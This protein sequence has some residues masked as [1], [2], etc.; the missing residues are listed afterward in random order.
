MGQHLF[1]VYASVV[2]YHASTTVATSAEALANTMYLE[3][4]LNPAL[5][6]GRHTLFPAGTYRFQGVLHFAHADQRS[7]FL[8]GA[9]LE[10]WDSDSY[11]LITGERQEIIGL[12][13]EA[14]KNL[15][16]R[17]PL[18]D[19]YGASDLLMQELRVSVTLMYH[20]VCGPRAAV[21]VMCLE[22]CR[23]VGGS[24]FGNLEPTTIGLWLASSYDY[25]L[26]N[27][28][29]PSPGKW[30]SY[31]L[32]EAQSTRSERQ[33]IG[34]QTSGAYEVEVF[35][36]RIQAFG[37][38]VR[39]GCTTDSADFI[40][41]IFADNVDGSIVVRDDG[42]VLA[43]NHLTIFEQA[44]LLTAPAPTAGISVVSGLTL[45][46]C[47]FSGAEPAQYVHVQAPGTE[48][49]G[50]SIQGGGV[51]GCTFGPLPAA[52]ASGSGEVPVGK[53]SPAPSAKD[54]GAQVAVAGIPPSGTA[55]VQSPRTASNSKLVPPPASGKGVEPPSNKVVP[56]PSSG[57]GVAQ[58]SSRKV[59]PPPS[60]GKGVAQPSS[61]KAVPPPSMGQNAAGL[62]V[63]PAVALS[64][65][66]D[67]CIFRIDGSISGVSVTGCRSVFSGGRGSVWIVSGSAAM[68]ETCDLFN[69]WAE[70]VATGDQ[71]GLLTRI[72]ADTSGV[73]TLTAEELCLQ[74][75]GLG[76]LDAEPALQGGAYVLGSLRAGNRGLRRGN[77]HLVLAQ[78]LID[79]SEL[80][81]VLRS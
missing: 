43:D 3:Q 58:P 37:W 4:A 36:T 49:G 54:V 77:E 72:T 64:G 59:V 38:A 23:F 40:A 20:S 52:P 14:P 28:P 45:V 1:D 67:G 42:D 51:F 73:L 15:Y 44:L 24:I 18:V 79:L 71:A 57:K 30:N 11:L 31:A 13:V 74:T 75:E 34:Q 65:P 81:L 56:P 33:R 16:A 63:V 17:S 60:S 35:G 62:V 9:V 68:K 10:P 2:D 76:V 21:R 61:S 70:E 5:N 32:L 48:S 6:G 80:G 53:A 46:G 26:A 25:D 27:D 41:C 39:I 12:S 78:L 66:G 69:A 29:N 47:R 7:T 22:R 50:G 55:L 8:A 19:I